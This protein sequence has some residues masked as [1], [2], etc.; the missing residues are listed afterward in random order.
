MSSIRLEQLHKT[1]AGLVAVDN[2]DLDI[3]D[4]EFLVLLGPSGCGKTTTLNCVAGLEQPTSGRIL[5]DGRDVTQ[6]PPHRRNI[7]MVFQSALL[8]PHMSGRR[9]IEASLKHTRLSGPEKERRIKEVAAILNITDMLD[10]LPSRMSGGQRQR[11]AIAK[12]IVRQPTVFLLDEPLSALDAALRL[13]LRAEIVNLQ[14]RLATTAVFVT[15]DQVEAMTMGDRIAVMRDGRLE[16]IGTPDEIYNRPQT[17]FVASFVGSPPMNLIEG[18]VSNGRFRSGPLSVPVAAAPGPAVLGV[19]PQDL[20]IS[21]SNDQAALPASVFALEHLGRE[22]VVVAETESGLRLR[23]LVAPGF[24]ARV[25]DVLRLAPDADR[26]MLFGPDGGRIAG[27]SA[28]A[29]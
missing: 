11:V 8:Y 4:G 12:A 13:T 22:A 26:C 23:V 3:R 17:L 29:A 25:G 14:K 21:A 10:K 9:N 6:D 27:A 2:L 24:T 18:E 20:R 19:R 1:F 16:Q 5:F 15:H 28:R 7:A